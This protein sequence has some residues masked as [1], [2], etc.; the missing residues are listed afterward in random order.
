MRQRSHHLPNLLLASFRVKTEQKLCILLVS[1]VKGDIEVETQGFRGGV[2]GS[3]DKQHVLDRHDTLL[4]RGDIAHPLTHIR[5]RRL[6]E[7][8]SGSTPLEGV[9]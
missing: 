2:G 7:S 6:Q 3:E 4:T 1:P 5:N 8:L 9:G